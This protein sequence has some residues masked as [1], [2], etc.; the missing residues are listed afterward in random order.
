VTSCLGARDD[1]L[2]GATALPGC[3]G[4][5]AGFFAIAI[6]WGIGLGADPK[7]SEQYAHHTTAMSWFIVA[8]RG[9]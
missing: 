4:K 8:D 1:A 5:R 6:V 3:T 2:C 9:A 7:G